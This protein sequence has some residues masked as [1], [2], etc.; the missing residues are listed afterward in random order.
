[1]MEG[2]YIQMESLGFYIRNKKFSMLLMDE[3]IERK[4]YGLPILL[5]LEEM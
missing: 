3:Y 4:E 5:K 1:M 2:Y